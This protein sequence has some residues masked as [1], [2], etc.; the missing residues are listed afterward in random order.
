MFLWFS[1]GLAV[2]FLFFFLLFC[3]CLFCVFWLSVELQYV[4]LGSYRRW[5]ILRSTFFGNRRHFKHTGN[6]KLQ[7]LHLQ[8]YFNKFTLIQQYVISRGS[9]G[10]ARFLSHTLNNK[11]LYQKTMGTESEHQGPVCIFSVALRHYITDSKH[12][13]GR[14]KISFSHKYFFSGIMGNVFQHSNSPLRSLKQIGSCK[15][16]KAQQ[17]THLFTVEGNFTIIPWNHLFFFPSL[18][19]QMCGWSHLQ[20]CHNP[21]WYVRQTP[22]VTDSY[23]STLQCDM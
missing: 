5:V 18:W 13:V 1:I 2:L 3:V 6:E 8:K 4:E 21:C 23:W 9:H 10:N 14:K 19:S 17:H 16:L 11:N 12:I 15:V 22:E 20:T 7:P